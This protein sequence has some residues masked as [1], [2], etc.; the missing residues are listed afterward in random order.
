MNKQNLTIICLAILAYLSATVS[1]YLL[2]SQTSFGKKIASTLPFSQNTATV[3]TAHP[4]A[5]GTMVFDKTAPRTESCPMNGVMYSQDQKNWWQQH[6]PLGV[7][8]ENHS[9]ARPQSGISYADIVYEAVAEGGITRFLL[10]F[11]CQD[12]PEVGPVRSAR[13]YFI[14]F[15]SE[16]GPYPLYTHVGGANAAGDADALGV[17]T[18]L[19]WTGY[20]DLNQFSIGFPTF[21]RDYNRQGHE[22]AT[23]HTMYSTTG[24]LWAYAKQNRGIT[25]SN[26]S[27]QWDKTFTPYGF[28]DDAGSSS[29]PTS[30][31]IHLEFWTGDPD[32][33]VDWRY[34]PKTNVYKRYDGTTPYVDRDNNMQLTTKN[35]VV[36][37]MIET[38]ADDGYE[39]NVHLLYQNIGSGKADVFID[40][41]QI[42]ATWKKD[43]RTARTML[44]DLSGNPIKFDRG[45]IWFSV[46]PLTGVMN[47]K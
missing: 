7:M 47:V 5:N 22:V 41:K 1:S 37:H 3:I 6:A 31:S 43:S 40:G 24:K 17:I 25:S 28:K 33:Y 18:D 21:W 36:M 16:Y 45:T 9:E 10:I 14:N 39:N 4:D 46:L 26:K 11:D 19:G 12:A 42:K 29:R 23:E 20:N 44:Y 15:L 27:G 38:H 30:Q 13:V 35:L 8:V 34:D 2:F 32:Y